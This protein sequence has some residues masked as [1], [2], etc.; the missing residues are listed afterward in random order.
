MARVLLIDTPEAG[1]QEAVARV[2]ALAS[3]REMEVMV[4]TTI[5]YPRADRHEAALVVRDLIS[6]EHRNRVEAIAEDL[7]RFG[8]KARAK[9]RV[10]VPF[11]EVIREAHEIEADFVVKVADSL[12][13]KGT[14]IGTTD[15]HLLRKCPCPVW[16]TRPRERAPYERV[17]AAVDPS[18]DGSGRDP[19]LDAEI[20]DH[21]ARVAIADGA[22]LTILHAWEMVGEGMLRGLARFSEADVHQFAEETRETHEAWVRQLIDKK[23]LEGLEYDIQVVKGRP[24]EVIPTVVERER[25]DLL[26]MGTLVRTGIRGLFIGSTAEEVLHQVGCAIL[27]LKPSDF[28]SPVLAN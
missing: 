19:R 27:A 11:V 8:V 10:G 9:V 22:R 6:K 3:D 20:L 13:S 21:A 5:D 26:V 17:F 15:L 14:G 12:A 24:K 4:L 23:V 7:E 1:S 2:R 25:A 18:D 28:E 16:I